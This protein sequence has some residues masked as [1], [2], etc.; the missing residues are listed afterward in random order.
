M[1]VNSYIRNAI[2]KKVNLTKNQKQ[3]K[4]DLFEIFETMFVIF[5][6]K[7]NSS[8]VSTL[9]TNALELILSISKDNAMSNFLSF[10]SVLNI[11][12]SYLKSKQEKL[13]NCNL[14]LLKLLIKDF[15]ETIAKDDTFL[16]IVNCLAILE[17][18]EVGGVHLSSEAICNVVQVLI[19]LVKTKENKVKQEFLSENV[20]PYLSNLIGYL[21]PTD[22]SNYMSN[23]TGEIQINLLQFLSLL[24]KRNGDMRKVLEDTFNFTAILDTKAE[25]IYK[26]YVKK[27]IEGAQI[28]RHDAELYEKLLNGLIECM[29]AHI[30][31]SLEM[32]NKV[33]LSCLNYIKLID[34]V[35]NTKIDI[36]NTFK[37][38]AEIAFDTLFKLDFI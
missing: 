2:K 37:K 36:F 33:K 32:I 17:R 7:E 10:H 16:I 23:V 11:I 28:D 9:A 1:A 35:A 5:S 31:S 30:S 24:L 13:M 15:K 34:N 38:H 22:L 4:Q 19:E 14:K 18:T 21:A 25:E 8:V 29:M 3:T 26:N 6:N 12:F 27:V 20:F